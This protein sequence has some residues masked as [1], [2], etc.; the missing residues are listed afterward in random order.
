MQLPLTKEKLYKTHNK[1]LSIRF[2][3]HKL[4]ENKYGACQKAPIL[5][6]PFANI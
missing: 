4:S 1:S 2:C 3:F 5:E 6:Y